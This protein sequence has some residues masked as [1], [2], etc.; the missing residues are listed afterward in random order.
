MLDLHLCFQTTGK[1]NLIS[2]RNIPFDLILGSNLVGNNNIWLYKSV[3]FC[4]E[5][6]TFSFSI[7]FHAFFFFLF[8]FM[9]FPLLFSSFICLSPLRCRAA[10]WPKSPSAGT[11]ACSP[12]CCAFPEMLPWSRNQLGA[13]HLTTLPSLPCVR[14]LEVGRPDPVRRNK[15]QICCGKLRLI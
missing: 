2:R 7:Q 14:S 10:S 12:W 1:I 9:Y 13:S 15:L 5:P 6:A 8:F 4:C 3:I 11:S